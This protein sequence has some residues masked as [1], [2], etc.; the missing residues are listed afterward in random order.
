M[1]TV[2]WMKICL[3]Y[4]ILS[5]FALDQFANADGTDKLSSE[6]DKSPR[7]LDR[8]IKAKEGIDK[9]EKD[10]R[11]RLHS[12]IMNEDQ[13]LEVA[14]PLLCSAKAGTDTGCGAPRALP[15]CW[16]STR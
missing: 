11:A 12:E 7:Y 2:Q 3:V 10:M 1:K 15:R 8:Y 13:R 4:C 6:I 14:T 9:E 5:A 16:N